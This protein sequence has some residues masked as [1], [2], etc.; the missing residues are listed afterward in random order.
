MR[1]GQAE[2]GIGGIH[3]SPVEGPPQ[4]LERTQ[5]V[6]A[7]RVDVGTH[8]RPGR[9]PFLGLVAPRDLDPHLAGSEPA[10]GPIVG[11]G[12]VL[13]PVGEG[14]HLR[15]AFPQELQRVAGCATNL[16]AFVGESPW[17]SCADPERLTSQAEEAVDALRSG[18]SAKALER[19]ASTG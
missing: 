12:H 19:M 18:P 17:K 13:E 15:G 16:M 14:Q 3:R 8:T 6:L 4:R 10:F 2:A 7:G 1:C 9:G 5:P 11:K